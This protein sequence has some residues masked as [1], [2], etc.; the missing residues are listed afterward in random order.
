ME[1]VEERQWKEEEKSIGHILRR[2]G[3]FSISGYS[4]VRKKKQ[5]FCQECGYEHPQW[6]GKCPQ[7]DQWNTFKEKPCDEQH[8]KSLKIFRITLTA[9]VWLK[10]IFMAFL[11]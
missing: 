10:H 7:C 5:Y 8:F 2:I 9:M 1:V 11:L 6:L 4:M 3:T